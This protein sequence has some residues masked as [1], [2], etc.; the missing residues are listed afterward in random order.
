MNDDMKKAFVELT[1][2]VLL[3]DDIDKLIEDLIARNSSAEYLMKND[4]NISEEAEGYL[5][6][7]T[8]I[9]KRLEDER[10]KLLIEM[11]KLSKSKAVIRTYAPKFPFP[12]L[13][14]FFEKKG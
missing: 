1:E 9:L 14:V 7:E 11:D 8:E 4:V 12:P 5:I 3:E 2:K 6:K 10:K 13:P